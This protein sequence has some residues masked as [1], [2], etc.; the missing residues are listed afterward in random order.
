MF[1]V[2]RSRMEKY[3][4]IKDGVNAIKPHLSRNPSSPW[5]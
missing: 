4:H 2:T 1:L 5:S 3:D